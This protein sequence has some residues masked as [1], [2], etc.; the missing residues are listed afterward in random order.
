M[1]TRSCLT[2]PRGPKGSKKGST[3]EETLVEQGR[4]KAFMAKCAEEAQQAKE[5]SGISKASESTRLVPNQYY[6]LALESAIK[7]GLGISLQTFA[8]KVPA[9]A[10]TMTQERFYVPASSL[11]NARAPLPGS[12]ARQRS[13]ISDSATGERRLE[14]PELI[15]VE[16]G[17]VARPAIHICSGKEIGRAHV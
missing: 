8:S 2:G 12:P 3:A 5:A 11:P 4:L 7:G 15:L 16:G 9:R 17:P 13:C 14:I 10:L 6:I 1:L